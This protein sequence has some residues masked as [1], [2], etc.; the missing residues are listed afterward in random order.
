MQTTVA[1]II[2]QLGGNTA[3]ARI[4]DRKPSAVSEMKRR[5]SIPVEYWPRLIDAARGRGKLLDAE[6]LMAAT[7]SSQEKTSGR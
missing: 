7:T 6:A 5:G 3:V 4:I 1:Q 2:E